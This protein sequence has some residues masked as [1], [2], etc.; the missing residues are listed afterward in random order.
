M[1]FPESWKDW[2][3]DAV[4]PEGV[5]SKRWRGHAKASLCRARSWRWEACALLRNKGLCFVLVVRVYHIVQHILS[6]CIISCHITSYHITSY[7]IFYHIVFFNIR[8]YH[9]ISKNKGIATIITIFQSATRIWYVT[10]DL[11]R[12][13]TACLFEQGYWTN[14]RRPSRL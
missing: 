13:V 8:F 6:Y 9:I 14:L 10:W 2:N 7:I 5:L 12:P 1:V 11:S 3:R 4:C